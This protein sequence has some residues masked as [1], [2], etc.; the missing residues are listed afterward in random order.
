LPKARV[1]GGV[2]GRREYSMIYGLRVSSSQMARENLRARFCVQYKISVAR[3]LLAANARACE[4][5]GG[6]DKVRGCFVAGLKYRIDPRSTAA[7]V[8]T[9]RRAIIP[10]KGASI[11]VDHSSCWL[12][13]LVHHFVFGHRIGDYR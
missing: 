2:W 9:K 10:F 6:Y 3:R 12:D 5:R 8:I 7:R 11:A 13:H 4:R 1:D